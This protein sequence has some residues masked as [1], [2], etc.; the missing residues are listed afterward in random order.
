MTFPI[1]RNLTNHP[2]SVET[3][4]TMEK[5]REQIQALAGAFDTLLPDGREASLALT[6]LEEMTMWAMASLARGDYD[7]GTS[8]DRW[9]G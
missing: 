8:M 9:A 6:K 4:D 7:A 5:L 2:P 1:E 3:A